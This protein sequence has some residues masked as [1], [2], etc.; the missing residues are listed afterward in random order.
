MKIVLVLLHFGA[1]CLTM[2]LSSQVPDIVL[3]PAGEFQMGSNNSER[4]EKPVHTVCHP[5]FSK[6]TEI[7]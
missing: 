4:D 6:E 5:H 1:F 2:S 3:I 7:N